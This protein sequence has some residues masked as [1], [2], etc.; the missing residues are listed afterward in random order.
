M[1]FTC[2]CLHV[3]MVA[4][5]PWKNSISWCASVTMV[6]HVLES[7]SSASISLSSI[8]QNRCITHPRGRSSPMQIVGTAS[9]A[10]R[11]TSLS[12]TPLTALPV[13]W[14]SPTTP[15]R[16]TTSSSWPSSEWAGKILPCLQWLPYPGLLIFPV[17]AQPATFA[18]LD[19]AGA[20][21]T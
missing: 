18:L 7:P 20:A 17:K 21:S 19:N 6:S 2:A 11:S 1:S 3:T 16:A 13:C 5:M 12:A 15:A 8:V 14:A 10:K 4:K 9:L